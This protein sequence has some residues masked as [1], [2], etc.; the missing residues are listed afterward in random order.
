RVPGQVGGVAEAE[1]SGFPGRCIHEIRRGEIVSALRVRREYEKRAV[2]VVGVLQ[3]ER[4]AE[5]EG[6]GELEVLED[7]PAGAPGVRQLPRDVDLV[8]GLA[9]VAPR[10]DPRDPPPGAHEAVLDLDSA[11]PEQPDDGG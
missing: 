6:L 1:V 3:R 8:E 5:K 10:A 11:A 9:A 7:R 4:T 2:R